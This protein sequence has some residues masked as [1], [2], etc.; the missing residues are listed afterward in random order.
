[1]FIL[2]F[3]PNWMFYVITLSGIAGMC[4]AVVFSRL[5]PIT[6]K[7]PLELLSILLFTFGVYTLG[8]ISTEAAW[9]L[10]VSQMEAE[11]AKKELAAAEIT[12]QVITKYVDRVQIVKGKTNVIIKKV[13][14]YINKESDSKCVVNTG[15][16][17]LLNA[18]AKNE[19]PEPTGAANES[20]TKIRLSGIAENVSRNYGTYYEVVE[21]LKALQDW[22]R[23][24]KELDNAK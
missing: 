19:V 15:F 16:V 21:Q 23:Q 22:V 6:Y 8:A 2:N 3:I 7:L 1:M 18:S 4:I 17:Q 13:P 20:P 12:A 24:Q 10:K 14:E 9:Q 11:I 5:I